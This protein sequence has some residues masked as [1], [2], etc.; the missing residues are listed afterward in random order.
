VP[1]RP[2]IY[3]AVKREQSAHADRPSEPGGRLLEYCRGELGALVV[4]R[5][6][7][8]QPLCVKRVFV[9][10]TGRHLYERE[11]APLTSELVQPRVEYDQYCTAL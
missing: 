8:A 5:H 3:E 7:A 9:T 6:V 10:A 1:D 4:E 11:W 2:V